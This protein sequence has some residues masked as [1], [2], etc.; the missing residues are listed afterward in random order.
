MDAIR[1]VRARRAEMNVPPSKKAQLTV[2]T[3][4]A[5]RL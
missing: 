5:G 3:P 4:G 2:S 1:G